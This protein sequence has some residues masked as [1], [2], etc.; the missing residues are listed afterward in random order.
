MLITNF[1]QYQISEKIKQF[2]QELLLVNESLL[3]DL[4]DKLK[5]W[6]SNQIK[7]DQDLKHLITS[8]LNGS[9]K[10]LAVIIF[11]LLIMNFGISKSDVIADITASDNE[12]KTEI[13]AELSNVEK[14]GID[15]DIYQFLTA[16]A[17]RESSNTPDTTNK[18]GYMG[19]YQFGKIALKDVGINT[20]TVNYKKFKEDPKIWNEFAQDKAM[21]KL[22]KN[23]IRYLGKYY[24][25]YDGKKINGIEITKS[26]MLGAA[27]LVGAKS[28]IKYL[29]SNGRII[30]KDG[31]GVSLEHYMKLF[32]DYN[33]S[34][35]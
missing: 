26:G 33:V 8:V 21:I 10:K 25:E 27:H 28:V 14:L 4:H 16:I 1:R 30:R 19:K 13:V 3:S 20:D 35:L 12:H 7:S 24:K 31:N 6:I 9:S 11:S 15:E 32:K 29:K 17:E 5:L 18:L 22:L 23:N 2:D 34:K